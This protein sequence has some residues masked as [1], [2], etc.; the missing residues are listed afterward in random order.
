[1]NRAVSWLAA[2]FFLASPAVVWW[3]LHD[4]GE[5]RDLPVPPVVSPA[6]LFALR[7]LAYPDLSGTRQSLQQWHG[8]VLVLNWWA[9]WCGPCREEMPMLS[10]LQE[11]YADRNVRFVGIAADDVAKVADFVRAHPV[12]YPLWVGGENAI[13][14]TRDLGNIPLA[15]PFTVVLDRK[16]SL[17]TAVLGRIEEDALVRLLDSLR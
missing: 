9:T 1:M 11:R 7:D 17:S 14:A 10:R 5:L 4:G 3:L 13:Q 16:G 15:V 6:A 2:A 12:G 8:D